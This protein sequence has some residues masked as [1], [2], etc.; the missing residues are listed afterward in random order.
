MSEELITKIEQMLHE[1]KWTRTA[2]GAYTVSLIKELDVLLVQVIQGGIQTEVKELC[3]NHLAEAKNSIV[4]LYL[5]GMISLERQMLDDTHLVKLVNLFAQNIKWPLVEHIA[6]QILVYGEN[7]FALRSLIDCYKNEANEAKLHETEERLIKVDIEEADIVF[8]LAQR[9]EKEKNLEK[10]VDYYKKG[11]HRFIHKKNF[12][13]IREIWLKLIEFCPEETDY[14][15][16]VES[17]VAKLLG[18]EKAC[19]LLE[20]L[21]P[22]FVESKKWDEAIAIQLKI[23]EY[24]PK[25][26]QVRREI[27]N[28]LKQKYASTPKTEEYLRL[29]NLSDSWKSVTDALEDFKKQMAYEKGNFVYHKAW[30]VGRIREV[31]EQEYIIDFESR[32]NQS[33]GQK[34]AVEALTSL[35]KDDIR[36]IMATTKRE[37]LAKRIKKDE[38]EIDWAL[39]TIIKSF[40]NKADMKLIKSVLVP[41][42]LEE[43]EWTTWSTKA[44]GR[45]KDSPEFTLS[46]DKQDEFMVRTQPISKEEKI[47]NKFRAEK[48]FFKRYEILEEFLEHGNRESDYFG[49]LFAS[50]ANYLKGT[51]VNEEVIAS[52]LIIQK[53]AKAFPF[54]NPGH[55]RTFLEY[56]QQIDELEPLFRN[57]ASAKL[58]TSF[59]QQVKLHV[60]NWDVLFVKLFPL[61]LSVHIIDD[62]IAAGKTDSVQKLFEDMMERHK[63]HKEA[64]FHAAKMTLDGRVPFT[65]RLTQEKILITL[66]HDLDLSFRDISNKKDV[67]DAKRINKTIANALFKDGVLEQYL[68]AAPEDSVRRLYSL[69]NDVRDL[70]PNLKVEVRTLVAARFPHLVAASEPTPVAVSS[71][72]GLLA[73]LKLFNAKK[74]ELQHVLDVEV[75][76]NAK[77]IGTAMAMGDLKENAEYHAAKEYQTMLSATVGTLTK[78]IDSATVIEPS[79][80]DVTKVGF[81]TVVSLVSNTDGKTETYT[82]LGPWESDPVNN[83]ISYLSPFGDKLLGAKV[84]EGLK[85]TI[86]ERKCDYTVKTIQL[87]S[88]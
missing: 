10:A 79:D 20:D 70:N 73:T 71:R 21:Y 67:T 36:V 61:S 50:F 43:R 53:Y 58:K 81:G 5:S 30:G 55:A 51:K 22:L 38:A 84:G 65:A 39:K 2:I 72:K 14:F 44:R 80:V 78:E 26:P 57:L 19:Q 46:P 52:Y 42:V 34:M 41:K 63:D 48:D 3:D 40:G 25:S 54:I 33:M 15:G 23:N 69:I 62:L 74:K 32:R 86:N 16:Q 28:C 59:L 17:K 24:E 77:E 29:S 11:I 76:K 18:A 47:Y 56:F 68:Q 4:A 66:V 60:P 83:V 13:R 6:N 45:I 35:A 75:P 27:I 88:F 8:S 82:I 12:N 87:A 31:K 37:D 9:Y 49:E 64:F 85:F 1:E 7:K